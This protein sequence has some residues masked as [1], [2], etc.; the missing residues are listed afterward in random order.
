MS[1]GQV[2]IGR[3][4]PRRAAHAEQR[5]RLRLAQD[6]LPVLELIP[7]QEASLLMLGHRRGAL[8]QERESRV[9]SVS[10]GGPRDRAG[11]LVVPADVG[12]AETAGAPCG[13]RID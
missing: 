7:F 5:A 11:P 3:A 4:S 6:A 10:I 12:V 2:G 1:A 13:A 8:G 9:S